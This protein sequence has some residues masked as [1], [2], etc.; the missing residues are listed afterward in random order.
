METS[1]VKRASGAHQPRGALEDSNAESSMGSRISDGPVV[2]LIA[3]NLV[4]ILM[5]AA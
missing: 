5:L 1:N 4:L 2:T 3:C